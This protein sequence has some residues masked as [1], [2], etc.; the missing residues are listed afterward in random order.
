MHRPHRPICRN[1][2]V[3]Q[4][5]EVISR[6][7]DHHVCNAGR[8]QRQLARDDILKQRPILSQ[9]R[10]VPPTL[11]APLGQLPLDAELAE[12]QIQVPA[13]V[14]CTVPKKHHVRGARQRRTR[15]RG[16]GAVGSQGGQAVGGGAAGGIVRL[17]HNEM[18]PEYRALRSIGVAEAAWAPATAAT[19][20]AAAATPLCELNHIRVPIP[21]LQEGGAARGRVR[22]RVD[23]GRSVRG[24][25]WGCSSA[26]VILVLGCWA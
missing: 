20:A 3:Q 18:S 9:Q 22:G 5:Q 25:G 17:L 12:G 2:V 21:T 14:Q 19:D 7:R 8:D 26:P 13:V 23:R 10:E 24:R 4:R 15:V 1:H 16:L 6:G 11:S